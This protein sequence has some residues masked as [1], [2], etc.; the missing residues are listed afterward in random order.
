MLAPVLNT[1]V[2]AGAYS[3]RIQGA[4]ATIARTNK[5][6]LHIFNVTLKGTSAASGVFL[7]GCNDAVIERS[8]FSGAKANVEMNTC[9]RAIVRFNSFNDPGGALPRGQQ[10]L[11][12]TCT[13]P[14]VLA[15]R[16]ALSGAGTPEDQVNFYQTTYGIVQGNWITGYGVSLVATGIVIDG[17][18]GVSTIGHDNKVLNNTLSGQT[19]GSG[20]GVGIGIAAGWNNLTNGNSVTGAGNV[21][22]YDYDQYATIAD[23]FAT[24]NTAVWN[25]NYGS[26]YA[27]TGGKLVFTLLVTADYS[28]LIASGPY[29]CTSCSISVE[30][31]AI[32]G[33]A[34]PAEG[35]VSWEIDSNS[36]IFYQFTGGNMNFSKTVG[37]VTSA[38]TAGITWNSVTHKFVRIREYGGTTFLDTSSDRM[39][40][41][42]RASLAN[43]FAVTALRFQIIGGTYNVSVAPGTFTL[44]NFYFST[45][46]DDTITGN[47]TSGGGSQ[48]Y[49][50]G[51]TDAGTA[52]NQTVSGNTGF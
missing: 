29:V 3:E 10:V 6:R 5:D 51:P 41:T 49:A 45:M 31:D 24:I 44:D 26:T 42:N 27:A 15:N 46:R 7:T 33:S 36:R 11:S 38:I 23:Q 40:W 30:I 13:F 43:P 32:P 39:T 48:F 1:V 16:M 52:P 17:A 4:F 12:D 25:G 8:T 22:I 50:G 18:V 34:K 47:I 21:N 2:L 9:A 35:Q 14:A 37:G 20:H 28:G 19:D